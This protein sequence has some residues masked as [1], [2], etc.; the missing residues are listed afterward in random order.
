ML[1]FL[2]GLHIL[3]ILFLVSCLPQEKT[4]Q[5][6]SNE[7]YDSTQRRCVATLGASGQTVSI[8]NI[9]PATSYTI[10]FADPSVTHSVT[11][12]D[13]YNNG[14]QLR[15][16]LTNSSG[17]QSLLATTTSLTFNHTAY[18]AGTYII[19]VQLLD[20]DGTQIFDS[21]SWTVNVITETTPSVYTETSPVFTTTISSAATTIDA[22]IQNPDGVNNITYTWY[23]NGASVSTGTTGAVST[24][25]DFS[26]DPTSGSG[27]FVGTGIYA[28][29][30][31]LTDASTSVYDSQLWQVTNTV[32]TFASVSLGTST[33][34]GNATP[35][36]G[37]VITAIDELSISNSGFLT[38]AD[39]LT[40]PVD[41][42]VY[43]TE[44]GDANLDGVN[45]DGVFVDYLI[46]GQPIPG[47][48]DIQMALEYNAADDST[49]Y[50]LSED[51][52]NDYEY[53]IPSNVNIES[54]T[55]SI[56]VYDK[57]TGTTSQSKYKGFNQIQR[58]D[59]T[60]R[61][62]RAN[63]PP[64]ITIADVELPA[65][66]STEPTPAGSQYQALDC[67]SETS[68]RYTGCKMTWGDNILN[69]DITGNAR[70]VRLRIEVEDDDYDPYDTSATNESANFTLE[71]YINGELADGDMPS[72][73]SFSNCNLTGD[74]RIDIDSNDTN[75]DQAYECDIIINPFDNDGP[76]VYSSQS[77]TIS[78]I[79]RD[80]GS[81]FDLG[82]GQASNEIEWVVDD[83]QDYNDDVAIADFIDSATTSS[84]VSL[85]STPGSA[86][87]LG[88]D[89]SVDPGLS[90]GELI[91]FHVQ[92][93]DNQRDQ[94]RISID[95][96]YCTEDLA[97]A[98]TECDPDDAAFDASKLSTLV[99]NIA[100]TTVNWGD[101][102]QTTNSVAINHQIRF[103][104]LQ[105]TD[106]I[107]ANGR[108]IAYYKVSVTDLPGAAAS[109]VDGTD[110]NTD[111]KPGCRTSEAV[112]VRIPI[113]NDNPDPSFDDP[114]QVDPTLP[115]NITILAGLPVTLDPGPVTDASTADG[116]EIEYQWVVNYDG[117]GN[118]WFPIEGANERI[119]SWTPSSE[120]VEAASLLPVAVTQFTGVPVQ[121][122]LCL[123][124]DGF[125]DGSQT[126]KEAYDAT[127]DD[128]TDA[129]GP[130]DS[131]TAIGSGG[132]GQAWDFNVIPNL[133]AGYAY[134]ENSTANNGEG[135]VATWVD[136]SS[137]DPIVQYTAYVTI[138][139]QI[140]VEKHVIGADGTKQGSL[141][142]TI[143]ATG[144]GSSVTGQMES[145]IFDASTD[146]A[147]ASNE[148]T[149]LSITGDPTNGSLY[150]SYMAPISGN[151]S[152]HIRRIDIGSGKTGFIHSGT[153]GWD[154]G[155]DDLTNNITVASTGINSESINSDG[156]AELVFTQPYNNG[157]ITAMTV[158]FSGLHGGSLSLVGGTDFCTSGCT[159]VNL[160]AQSF[161]TAINASTA[162]EIQGLRAVATGSTVELFGISEGDFFE[163]DIGAA[164]IGSIMV[165]ETNGKFQLP[166]IDV[167]QSGANKFKVS[168]LQG[169][170]GVRLDD[171]NMTSTLYS[172]TTNV[173]ASAI[174]NDI[175][176]N[177]RVLIA[178]K[179]LAGGEIHL[180]EVSTANAIVE[181]NTDLF[182]NSDVTKIKLSVSKE[183]TDFDPSVFVTGTNDSGNLALARVDSTGGD[184]DLDG[185]SLP[186][187][188]YEE[189]DVG[190]A[191]F[192]SISEYDI[193]AGPA[194][195][196]LL[197]AVNDDSLSAGN[198]HTYLIRIDGSAPTAKC[199]YDSA[200][201]QNLEKCAWIQPMVANESFNLG[202][203]LSDPIK[204]ITIGDEGSVSSENE[205]DFIGIANHIDE[206]GAGS[207]LTDAIVVTGF[208]NVRSNSLTATEASSSA[209][210][211]E[212]YTLP[213]VSP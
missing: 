20:E 14:Y 64:V 111:D 213:Y 104:A 205:G 99:P 129:G 160:T 170:L 12:S 26:F 116:D 182:S 188:S 138:N 199:S 88:E 58:Y 132:L 189:F 148:V 77:Y 127:N 186:I 15:W 193:V 93:T 80:N 165:N 208:L 72:K 66:T 56:V 95:Q 201:S 155:Y 78:A 171:A 128:C 135:A 184:Y 96:L 109:A 191:P 117:T 65:D 153:F 71:I 35:A 110:C 60:L 107:D 206:N 106:Q 202:V 119:L 149:N 136:P 13:S 130:M 85:P 10:S 181:T 18:S 177:D 210:N 114:G 44:N 143:S 7:A 38:P 40:T 86:I 108:G 144:E 51:G 146:G 68:T 101:V 67:S 54:H 50:C 97:T 48:I 23:V 102:S 57:F 187:Y 105:G 2:K 34:L 30:L 17:N 113:N 19:E 9:T 27:Y 118:D 142:P 200:D 94:H 91:Q 6:K 70:P 122:K 121:V 63:T 150:I 211:N 89:L 11:V 87:T 45:G 163:N 179:E 197:L 120:I 158:T 173:Q 22:T 166:Y 139:K 39:T 55:L 176:G 178:V 69:Y 5:C 152:V 90:E 79:V 32:P 3:S 33:T 98:V 81:P 137:T 204:N 73:Y 180:H 8:S 82:N 61:V 212:V 185:S 124:D 43:A 36:S 16:Y 145:I 140:V 126:L 74:T 162:T 115:T 172:G 175:D 83:V 203:A 159:T 28:I 134:D 164:I 141:D 31:V 195:A 190:F 41:F 123:G 52:Y 84:Y 46:D 75:D 1:N 24:D 151:D 168:V 47:A 133:S 192:A 21:R 4:T 25:V 209:S 103:D 125:I 147:F 194:E 42:C 169:D 100:T 49:V 183:T 112:Y 156:N 59:Y 76:L 198:Y 29:Q 131:S 161:A 37:T 92:V 62:R 174:A 53:D 154:P 196:Q 157:S 167:N 207:S